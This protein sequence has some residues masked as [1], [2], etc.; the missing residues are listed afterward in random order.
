M[1]IVIVSEDFDRIFLH[2][3]PSGILSGSG[4]RAQADPL[5]GDR[6]N[7]QPSTAEV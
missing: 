7:M 5:T 3:I 2:G 4:S 1:K 6:S